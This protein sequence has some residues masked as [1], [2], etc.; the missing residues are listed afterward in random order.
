MYCVCVRERESKRKRARERTDD[1]VLRHIVIPQWA[2]GDGVSERGRPSC[3]EL[4][5][6]LHW[7]SDAKGERE[8][9]RRDVTSAAD[10]VET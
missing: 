9:G 1:D 4:G 3:G 6:A 7:L 5:S 10:C 2:V 8:R